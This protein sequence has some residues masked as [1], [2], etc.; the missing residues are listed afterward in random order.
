MESHLTMFKKA[1]IIVLYEQN[2]TISEIARRLTVSNIEL[3][4]FYLTVRIFVFV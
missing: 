1:E 2:I 3:Q 4:I